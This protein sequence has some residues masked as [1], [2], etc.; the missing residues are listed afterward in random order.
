MRNHLLLKFFWAG[1]RT[2]LLGADLRQEG[3]RLPTFHLHFG[4][5]V[6]LPY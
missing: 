2:S 6:L 5:G 1:W 3:Y 4:S